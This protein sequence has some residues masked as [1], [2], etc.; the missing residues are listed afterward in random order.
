MSSGGD[1]TRR[2]MAAATAVILAAPMVAGA[3]APL[4][5][6]PSRSQAFVFERA[7]RGAVE[8]GGQLLAKQALILFPEFVLST[9]EATV[10][11]VRLAG[12]G[13][14]FDVQV[15]DI[16]STTIVLDMMAARQ[17][18]GAGAQP[19]SAV[20]G[21]LDDPMAVSSPAFDPNREYSTYVRTALIDTMLD[22]SG[23]LA[24][25]AGERLTVAVS[26]IEQRPSNPLYRSD[27]RK[28]IM[29]VDADT[30][31][32]LRQGRITRDEARELIVAET[33]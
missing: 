31:V 30:L 19:V 33:F 3:Q 26:G 27:S 23:V 18:R 15:P 14:Y 1:V 6:N 11:G 8:I 2:V 22:S 9:E 32:G 7:L 16:Q 25:D 21:V 24:L 17:R 12:Y 10:R 28:L 20:G 4:P 13:F 5:D 29:T